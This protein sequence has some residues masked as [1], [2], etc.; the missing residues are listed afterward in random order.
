MTT[1]ETS[2]FKSFV[3]SFETIITRPS[4]QQREIVNA[5]LYECLKQQASEIIIEPAADS[6]CDI[7]FRIDGLLQKA[8]TVSYS[9]AAS[10]REALQHEAQGLHPGNYDVIE[11][12]ISI[13]A[14]GNEHSF[15]F[16]NIPQSPFNSILIRSTAVIQNSTTNQ[17]EADLTK[18]LVRNID[19]KI[20]IWQM[21]KVG[22]STVYQSLLPYSK[23]CVWGGMIQKDTRRPIETNIIH[24][25]SFKLL[26]DFLH[27]SDQEF[28]IISLVR[29]LLAR[30]I[31]SIFQS[32]NDDEDAGRGHQ[33]IAS[34][35]EF[36]QWPYDQ[37]EKEITQHL[38][39]LNTG[40]TVTC[41][42]DNLLKSHFYYP[43]IDKYF[44][45]I[46]AKP[47][48]HENGYQIYESKT[49]RIKMII[50]RLEDLND[51][52]NIIGDFLGIDDLHLIPDNVSTEKWYNPIYKLFK[53]RYKPSSIEL[54]CIYNSRFMKYFYSPTQ[55][56]F[57]KEQWVKES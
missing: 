57:F 15:N 44:I 18:K 25:H 43:Q 1:E 32:M 36:Q 47:F 50:V 46:Y 22:S 31:S 11:G 13:S 51:K 4:Y 23:P 20:L 6:S 8:L 37:Q 2:Y 16:Y 30:N 17:K 48:D 34:I 7:F 27:Y 24:T 14:H 3:S 9:Q 40:T 35:D 53:E 52:K 56:K 5:L 54:E 26:Y 42:Y 19:N 10:L 39:R 49:S 29:D 45:D 33:F 21:G 41:W 55:I 12:T 28:V 38:T